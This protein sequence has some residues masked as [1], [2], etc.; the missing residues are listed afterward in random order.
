[1]KHFK[2]AESAMSLVHQAKAINIDLRKR[3]KVYTSQ[4]I[5]LCLAWVADEVTLTQVT[6]VMQFKA[7]GQSYLF[8]AMGLRQYLSE[9][10]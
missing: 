2:R 8:L 3:T 1:M 6:R 7:V 5:D 4:E 10:K 9:T